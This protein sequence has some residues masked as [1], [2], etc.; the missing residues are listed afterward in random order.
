MMKKTSKLGI[1]VAALLALGAGLVVVTSAQDGVD[2]MIADA[3]SAAPDSIA[4]DA[5]IVAYPDGP[6]LN[7][8][9]EGSNG[10]LCVSSSPVALAAGL[11]D[12]NCMDEVWQG[13]LE[14]FMAGETP[15]ID[16]IGISYMLAGDGGAGNVDPFA[17]GPEDDPTWHASGPH[18][19]ILMPD[20]D[21]SGVPTD[22]EYGGPYVMWADTPY[23]HIMI[24]VTDH[25]D[26]P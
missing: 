18:I 1:V 19:M 3:M 12:P 23:A 13:W 6:E 5:T 11:Q 7:V 20:H 17:M 16:S 15:E 2:E 25:D 21:Y 4:R 8:L 22:H 14:A 9:R 24:P 10:W 26:H